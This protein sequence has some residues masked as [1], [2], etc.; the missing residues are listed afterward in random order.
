MRFVAKFKLLVLTSCLALP[1][2]TLAQT[3]PDA[4]YNTIRLAVG[5][6]FSYFHLSYGAQNLFGPSVYA[7]ARITP[8]IGLEV[9]ARWLELNQK[10]S[11]HDE[12]YLVGPIY[13]FNPF[14]NFNPY[15]KVLGGNGQF[16][17]DDGYAHG[18]YLALAAGG[19]VN[20][21]LS[22]RWWLRVADVE[23]QRWPGFTGSSFSQFGVSSGI[24]Y[25]FW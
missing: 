17:F 4:T 3:A 9:E 21:Q 22:G 13:H 1:V 18:G 14:H 16:N 15:V 20:R 10:Y 7:D 2:C 25:R 24:S 8:R 23:Y 5:G 19:G 6:T 12:T 11:V